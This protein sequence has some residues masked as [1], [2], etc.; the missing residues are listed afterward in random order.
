MTQYP[1]VFN[2]YSNMSFDTTFT[3]LFG[4]AKFDTDQ[5]TTFR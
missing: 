5:A 4:A 3:S 1:S 2:L